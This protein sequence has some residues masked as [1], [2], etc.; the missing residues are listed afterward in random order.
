LFAMFVVVRYP[1]SLPYVL[2]YAENIMRL[3]LLEFSYEE[4]DRVCRLRTGQGTNCL[5]GSLTHT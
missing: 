4:G 2:P 5:Y 3:Q 1:V